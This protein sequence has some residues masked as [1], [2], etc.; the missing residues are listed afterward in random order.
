MYTIY[1][2]FTLSPNLYNVY[3]LMKKTM[4]NSFP[5]PRFSSC[6]EQN[7]FTLLSYVVYIL[8]GCGL[9][10][11]R[12]RVSYKFCIETLMEMCVVLV[13]L[14]HTSEKCVYASRAKQMHT[15]DTHA[16]VT[17]PTENIKISLKVVSTGQFAIC[18][19]RTFRSLY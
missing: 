15:E 14:T 12:E 4:A 7:F 5:H 11:I 8:V 17:L 1:I 3:M 19:C 9:V 18:M 13:T 6:L 16:D 10:C 2:I